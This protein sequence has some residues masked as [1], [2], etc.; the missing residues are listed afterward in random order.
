MDQ[1][2]VVNMKNSKSDKSNTGY[3]GI[4][5]RKNRGLFE[6]SIQVCRI[7]NNY[8]TVRIPHKINVGS[9]NSLKEAIEA[10]EDFISSLY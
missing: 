6:A 7:R 9:Y 3:R 8:G 4:Y 5:F 10:R 1:V 2:N